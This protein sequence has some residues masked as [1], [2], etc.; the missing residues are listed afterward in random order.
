MLYADTIDLAGS[1]PAEVA[2]VNTHGVVVRHNHKWDE[3]SRVGLLAPKPAGWNYF[4]ECEAAAARGNP[5]A[6]RILAGL[7][8]VLAGETPTF[9]ST[10]VCPFL[11]HWY[12]VAVSTFTAEGERHAVIMHADVSSLQVDALTGLANRAMF[13]AQLA[14]NLV[15]ARESGQRTGVIFVDINDLKSI[16]TTHGHLVGDEAVKAIGA[17]LVKIVGADSVVSRLGGDEFGV[18]LP[19]SY[20]TLTAPRLRLALKTGINCSIGSNRRPVMISASVGTAYYPDDGVTPREL[21]AAADKSMYGQKRAA[22][23][24]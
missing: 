17:A 1:L 12:Q 23:V 18:V 22:S 14:L 13:E 11:H 4:T 7:R 15:L 9:F 5:D 20:D 24:A 8:R 2:V 16:N 19:V 10:Y 21:L 3:R 6:P